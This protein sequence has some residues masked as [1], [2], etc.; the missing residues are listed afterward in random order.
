METVM[1]REER[2]VAKKI[3]IRSIQYSLENTEPPPGNSLSLGN[4]YAC[5]SRPSLP[6]VPLS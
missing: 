5:H 3:M 6:P 1:F 2:L 4:A